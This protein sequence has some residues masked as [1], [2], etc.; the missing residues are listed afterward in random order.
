MK[1]K[2]SI[3]I[4]VKFFSQKVIPGWLRRL[5]RCWSSGEHLHYAVAKYWKH[6]SSTLHGFVSHFF[7]IW[8]FS[9]VGTGGSLSGEGN[10]GVLLIDGEV[11]KVNVRYLNSEYIL[12][13]ISF[14]ASSKE[15][16]W[17]FL[18]GGQ[19]GLPDD[20]CQIES[21]RISW[22]WDSSSFTVSNT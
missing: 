16:R 19:R 21:W 5:R 1:W 10:P 6:Y 17:I 14:S 22:C 7:P 12:Q 11:I 3:S 20:C 15:N 9:F 8:I 13:K 4:L 18:F 2:K